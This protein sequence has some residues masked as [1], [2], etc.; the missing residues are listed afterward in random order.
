MPDHLER[1]G[2]FSDTTPDRWVLRGL[3]RQTP[4]RRV[5]L[6]ALFVASC[7]A[8]TYFE[9]NDLWLPR[10][11][12]A[13]LALNALAH[14]LFGFRGPRVK[15]SSLAKTPELLGMMDEAVAAYRSWEDAVSAPVLDEGLTLRHARRMRGPQVIDMHLAIA[16][17]LALMLGNGSLRRVPP[18]AVVLARAN[19]DEAVVRIKAAAPVA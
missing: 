8:F 1:F 11:I 3:A 2:G 15:R 7:I 16:A 13:G 18:E 10:A 9:V 12:S 4:M 5:G 14:L 17:G 19:L 6:F